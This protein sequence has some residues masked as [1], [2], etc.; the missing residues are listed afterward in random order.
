MSS[1]SNASSSPESDEFYSV[2]PEKRE[3]VKPR[4]DASAI[5]LPSG[6]TVELGVLIE[7]IPDMPS[8]AES[9]DEIWD[10]K[11]LFTDLKMYFNAK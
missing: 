2:K 4:F 8:P 11:T 3:I 6:K 1:I 10:T 9:R 7:N 5:K